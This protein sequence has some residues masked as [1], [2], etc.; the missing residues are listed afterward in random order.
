MKFI[1]VVIV[2]ICAALILLGILYNVFVTPF[3]N[4]KF[5]L[6]AWIVIGISFVAMLIIGRKQK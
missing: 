6:I 4:P 3:S 5:D 1:K 2:S